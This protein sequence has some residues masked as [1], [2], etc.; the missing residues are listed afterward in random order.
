MGEKLKSSEK[1]AGHEYQQPNIEAA[2]IKGPQA[3]EKIEV[4]DV[5]EARSAIEEAKP[6]A[7]EIVNE[8]PELD[9]D[10]GSSDVRWWSK[11]LGRQNLDRTLTSVRRN[12]SAPERQLS[13]FIHKPVVEKVS[14]LGGKTLA[15]PSGILLGGIFSFVGSLGVYLL[16][17]HMGGELHYSIFA[18]TF[19]LGYL[20][21]LIVELVWRILSRKKSS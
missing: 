17:R 20:L 4:L 12:L 10:N 1:E 6:V 8:K 13:K 3:V 18:A 15:R 14:D 7:K 9:K 11:E 5:S 19:V 16:A 21:G 2:E